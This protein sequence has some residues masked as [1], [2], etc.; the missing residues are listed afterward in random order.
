MLSSFPASENKEFVKSFLNFHA[1]KKRKSAK[2]IIKM[3]KKDIT[4]SSDDEHFE[5]ANE[6]IVNELIGDATGIK[7]SDSHL[8]DEDESE[9]EENDKEKFQ[10]CEASDMIDDESQRDLE[11]DQTEEQRDAARLEAEELKKRGNDE[12]KT[13]DYHKSADIYT[14]ALRICPVFCA[15]ERSVLYGNRAAA[16]QKLDFKPAAIDDCTKALEFNPNYVK[17]LLR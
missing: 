15:T 8:E 17:V 1:L 10:E 7:I 12:F 11:K 5:D 6:K 3:D 14:Q 16:K 2:Q 9:N 13:G 4:A